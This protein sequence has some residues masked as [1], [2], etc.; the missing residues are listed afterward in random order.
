MFAR[1][2]RSSLFAFFL[3]LT[4]GSA[5]AQTPRAEPIQ[6]HVDATDVDHRILSAVEEIPVAPGDLTLW[7]PRWIP[8]TH[9]TSFTQPANFV[10]LKFTANGQ[11]IEWRR[12]P[13]EIATFYLHIPEGVAHIKAEFQFLTPSKT[14]GDHDR[15]RMSRDMI[16]LSWNSILLYPAGP[17]IDQIPITAD[18]RLP[19]GFDFGSA[20]DVS[21]QEGTLIKF[22]TTDLDT[23]VDSPVLAGSH[24]RKIELTPGQ[25]RRV[26]LDVAGD[27]AADIAAT[28]EE[29]RAHMALVQQARKLFGAEHYDHYD[30]LLSLSDTIGEEGLEHHQ[31]S[32]DGVGHDYFTDWSGGWVYRDLLPHEYTHSWNGKF[33]RPFDLTTAN[34]NVPMKDTLL[35]MYEGQTQFWGRV[36]AARAGLETQEQTREVLAFYADYYRRLTGR[37]WRNLQDTTNNEILSNHIESEWGDYV[38]G[39]D[40]YEEMV[41]VWLDVDSKIREASGGKRSLDDFAQRFFG[42]DDGQYGVRTY[43]FEDIVAA[44]NQVEPGD[45]RQFLRQRL[46]QH[47]NGPLFDGLTRSGWQVTYNDTPNQAAD[48]VHKAEGGADFSTSI[49]L[50]I[51]KGDR[52]KSVRW[53]GPAFSAG[54]ATGDSVIAVNGRAY[55]SEYL[56]DAIAASEHSG[57]PIEILLKDGELYRTVKI[58][59][60][61]GLHY[62]HLERIAGSHDYLS[63]LLAPR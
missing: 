47:D 46:D 62:P 1:L 39:A 17:S 35:W 56:S 45:W 5:Q 23:L 37:A 10:G 7:Y 19:E 38:R 27:R 25:G 6:L 52:V 20:L 54:V 43:T 50:E 31:S 32:E 21:H 58:D 30:F 33:R 41:Y 3:A 16:A 2:D 53:K 36:L 60:H 51:G 18:L 61:G 34:Y 57:A 49:G 63:E 40:Y 44:L 4:C 29:I 28:D 15:V 9:S 14:A 26:T 12:D 22:K 13:V 48:A 11:P 42:M 59:W 55:K 8:G 24:F